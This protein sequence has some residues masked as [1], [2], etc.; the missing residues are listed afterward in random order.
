MCWAGRIATMGFKA[1]EIG[2]NGVAALLMAS[3]I[4]AGQPVNQPVN[5]GYAGMVAPD[6]FVGRCL[7]M[8]EE[9]RIKARLALFTARN[10]PL[11]QG[12]GPGLLYGFYPQG[13]TLYK[14]LTTGNFV[15]LD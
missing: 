1:C 12:D 8:A 3:G 6:R 15:D 10:G 7:P 2:G 13:G 5:Q 14:D 11:S 9:M 4:A